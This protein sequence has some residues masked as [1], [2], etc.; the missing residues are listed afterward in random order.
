MVSLVKIGPTLNTA[1]QSRKPLTNVHFG[2]ARII[3]FEKLTQLVENAESWQ[4]A[5]YVSTY[6]EMSLAGRDY[7]ISIG[8]ID[9]EKAIRIDFPATNREKSPIFAKVSLLAQD[10]KSL[11]PEDKFAW[12]VLTQ[13]NKQNMLI[14]NS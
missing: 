13:L 10:K 5:Q 4:F 11:S 7:P 9:G 12:A 14:Q 6:I 2:N 3:D 8:T 1:A